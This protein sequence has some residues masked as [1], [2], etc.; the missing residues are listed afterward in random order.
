MEEAAASLEAAGACAESTFLHRQAT[1]TGCIYTGTH[2]AVSPLRCTYT[3][4]DRVVDLDGHLG[5]VRY[6]GPVEGYSRRTASASYETSSSSSLCEDAEL[7]IGIEWDDA[8][9]GKH[10]GSLNGKVYFSCVGSLR[11]KPAAS[12]ADGEQAERVTAGSFVKRHKLLEPTDFKRA[13]LERYTEKLTQEQIDSMLL[14]NPLTNKT[15]PVE[16]VGRKEAEEHFARLHLLNAMSFTSVSA[17]R[18]AGP[19]PHLLLPN[20]RRL[21][22]ANSLIT[23][24]EEL[25]GILRCVPRLSSLSLCGTRLQ[26]STLPSG[27]FASSGKAEP[28]GHT[29]RVIL[30]ELNDLQLDGT[31]VTW[32]ELL[33]FDALAP[34]LQRLSIRGND[35]SPFERNTASSPDDVLPPFPLFDPRASLPER[36]TE[37]GKEETALSL[38]DEHAPLPPR[39]AVLENPSSRIFHGLRSLDVSDNPIQSWVA[40]FAC[41]RHLP[42][43]ESLCAV[44]AELGDFSGARTPDLAACGGRGVRTAEPRGAESTATVESAGKQTG[45]GDFRETCGVGDS[46]KG[47]ACV[48]DRLE[49]EAREMGDCLAAAWALALDRNRREKIRELCVEDNCVDQWETI[50]ALARLFPSLQRLMIQGNPLLQ[51]CATAKV[52][53]VSTGFGA[54]SP[55]RQVV[56][57]LFPCLEVLSGGTISKADRA[58]A[59]K[60]TLSLLHRIRRTENENSLPIPASLI[61]ALQLPTPGEEHNNSAFDELLDRLTQ[62]H[63]DFSL[64]TTQGEGGAAVLASSLIGILLQPDA[65]SIFDKPAVKK[66]IP[67]SMRVRDLKTLCMRLFGLPVAHIELLYNDGKMPVSTPLDDDAASLDFFGVDTGSVVRVQDKNDRRSA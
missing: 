16:F 55:Q 64:A 49:K 29:E 57:S 65:A 9:R 48:A 17:I 66:R 40:I 23:N 20:L 10:D 25:L 62:I 18:Y 51:P 54:S 30:E 33:A 50:T 45:N 59:E 31:F 22:L 8:G 12:G 14:V 43:L 7:W 63:G 53:A 2:S 47:Y 13:V 67:K 36:R 26:A 46:A 19:P 32:E 58:A 3:P 56:I 39:E 35:L 4:G 1:S 21:S 28:C 34:N 6:I 42:R 60:Y 27:G 38:K 15:K 37:R 5:T 41:M 24:W 11:K 52:T 61:E 44:N